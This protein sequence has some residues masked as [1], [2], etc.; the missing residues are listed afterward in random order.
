[1][2]ELALARGFK[3]LTM[4]GQTEATARISYVPFSMLNSKI[5]SIGIAIPQGALHLDSSG[6]L[7]YR[8]PNVMMGYAECRQDLAHGDDLHG[9]LQTG[10]LARQDDDG[11]F[12]LTGRTKRFLK[13]F[14]KRFNLDEAELILQR[15][16]AVAVACFGHDDLLGVAIECEDVAAVTAMLRDTFGLPADAL[17]VNAIAALPRTMS[18]KINYQALVASKHEPAASWVR[19]AR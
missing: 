17:A 4:Y 2:Y 15:R 19:A 16:F 12:Y 6:E 1:M 8:G 10:D 3:F 14:G 18:G 11:Y 5:G 13:M 9:T 7:V